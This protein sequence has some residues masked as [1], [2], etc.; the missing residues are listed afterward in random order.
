MKTKT[1]KGKTTTDSVDIEP[2]NMTRVAFAILGATPL[3]YH[4]VSEK[5]R[6]QLML[7]EVKTKGGRRTTLKHNPPE[8]YRD[9]VYRTEDNKAPTR[10]VLPSVMFKAA[11]RSV[12]LDMEGSSKSAIG[13]LT[14]VEGDY[15]SLY[16]VPKLLMSVVRNSDPGRTPDIRTRAIVPEWAC[17]ISI[18]YA[19]P[20]LR[21]K[22]IAN[23]L[24]AAGQL[25]GIGDWRQEKGSGN[26]GT[27]EIVPITDPRYQAIV[28]SGGR[29]AQDEAL[30]EPTPYD[31]D[32]AKLLSYFHQEVA[33]RGFNSGEPLGGNR[34]AEVLNG[35]EA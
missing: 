14:F 10:L 1:V 32:S 24:S 2:V 5:A 29:K 27:F 30:A 35:V 34:L 11:L 33:R 23:L 25:R 16:G 21:E 31:T 17:Q 6:C 15:V 8:E 7:P 4:A 26:Y 19:T 3:I 13:R 28:K 18:K 12:A 20:L 9:S 22:S